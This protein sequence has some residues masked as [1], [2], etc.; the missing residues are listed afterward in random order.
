MGLIDD[1]SSISIHACRLL[2]LS[3]CVPTVV[4][5]ISLACLQE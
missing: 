5:P 4:L 2:C 3:L 1:R